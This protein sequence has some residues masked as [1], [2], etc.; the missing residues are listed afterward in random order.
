M[1]SII[2]AVGNRKEKRRLGEVDV[3]AREE[4]PELDLDAR[5]ELIRTLIPLG[6][7]HVR[8]VLNDE[9]TELAGA[10]HARA[11]ETRL[12]LRQ[13]PGA[14]RLAGQKHPIR[15]PRVRSAQGEIPL[16]SYQTLH[17]K[18]DV[19]E[20]LLKRVLYRISYRNYEHAAKSI[21]GAIGLS[22]STV[23]RQFVK[24]SAAM[25]RE[26]QERI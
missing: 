3:I 17:G 25:L 20:L 22:S 16:R 10:R 6:L 19:D 1:G 11:R 5:V 18:G 15:V 12:P 2:R 9:V 14:V 23:S 4:Y 21:P 24:A 13:Q 26:F 8:E 7:M